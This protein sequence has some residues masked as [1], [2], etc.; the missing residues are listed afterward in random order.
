MVFCL[1]YVPGPLGAVT[2]FSLLHCV[3]D[4]QLYLPLTL[5]VKL[6]CF[7][8]AFRLVRLYVHPYLSTLVPNA[9]GFVSEGS[10]NS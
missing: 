2:A 7:Y 6:N 9:S 4:S 5:L 3:S 10:G 8:E 1:L